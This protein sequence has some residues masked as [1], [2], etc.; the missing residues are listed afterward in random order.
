M[1][2]FLSSSF[3]VLFSFSCQHYFCTLIGTQIYIYTQI[4]D[5][6]CFSICIKNTF[7]IWFS[8]LHWI[9][10][11]TFFQVYWYSIKIICIDFF[12][13]GVINRDAHQYVCDG[14]MNTFILFIRTLRCC[15]LMVVYL[16]TRFTRHYVCIYV[17]MYVY[18]R[19]NNDGDCDLQ[20]F[21]YCVYVI[22]K[23]V[24]N[25]YV[26]LFFLLFYK[27]IQMYIFAIHEQ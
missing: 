8:S 24:L 5:A 23:W 13:K 27:Y 25:V 1:I 19:K 4:N 26:S 10:I 7:D 11:R 17:C 3:N 9:G 21:I 18:L 16:C 14:G 15:P 20:H 6:V 2:T 12:C 22:R